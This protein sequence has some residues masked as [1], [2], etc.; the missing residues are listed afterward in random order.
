MIG[1]TAE[2][3]RDE[4]ADGGSIADVAE[5]HGVDPAEVEAALLTELEERIAE[6]VE[7]GRLDPERATEI[8]DG[9]AE[10]IHEFVTKERPAR[11][12]ADESGPEV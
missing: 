6:A 3:F 12:D 4:M 1:I 5:A 11:P 8:L 7:R 9:A 2:E 10:R